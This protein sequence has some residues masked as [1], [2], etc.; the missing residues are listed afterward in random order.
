MRGSI[1][2]SLGRTQFVVTGS[3]ADAPTLQANSQP[4]TQEAVNAVW[5]RSTTIPSAVKEKN[6]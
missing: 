6:A 2:V 1:V 4:N 3:C 5:R